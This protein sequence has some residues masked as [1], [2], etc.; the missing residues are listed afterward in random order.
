MSS[1]DQINFA[2]RQ[3][4]AIERQIAFEGIQ[5]LL[6]AMSVRNAVYVGLGSVWFVDFL[7]A[8]RML[9]CTKMVSIEQDE[10][11]YRRAKFNRPWRTVDVRHG[12]SSAVIPDLLREPAYVDRPWIVWLDIDSAVDEGHIAE[13][14]SLAVDLPPDSLLL[15]TF[16][17][18]DSTYGTPADRNARLKSLFGD[19][20]DDKPFATSAEAKD[21]QR[22]MAVLSQAMLDSVVSSTMKSGRV[23]GIIPAFRLMYKDAMPMITVGW[24]LPSSAKSAEVRA[25]VGVSSWSATDTEPII[26]PPLTHKELLALQTRMP[27]TRP[28]SEAAVSRLG[29]AL[30]IGARTSYSKHYLRYPWYAELSS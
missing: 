19:A 18:V 1:T 23:G 4:K 24:A 27:S 6:N 20:I 28:L 15:T 25:I 26:T 2:L 30:D 22:M 11:V 7:L 9:G 8:H 12:W 5:Q 17:A 10:I 13:I 29:F 16:K 14:R 21:Q 3:N